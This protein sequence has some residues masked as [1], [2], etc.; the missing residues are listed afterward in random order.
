LAVM[1]IVLLSI[2]AGAQAFAA[3]A[4]PPLGFARAVDC[5]GLLHGAEAGD[6]MGGHHAGYDRFEAAAFDLG[7]KARLKQTQV[8]RAILASSGR[9]RRYSLPRRLQLVRQCQEIVAS[10]A[11]TGSR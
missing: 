11:G 4:P 6:P 9:S 3:L 1:V 8:R 2:G 7:A 5:A 10:T